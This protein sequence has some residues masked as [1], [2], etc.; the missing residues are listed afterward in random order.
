MTAHDRHTS[1]VVVTIEDTLDLGKAYRI[2]RGDAAVRLSDATRAQCAA[3]HKTLARAVKENRQIYG[4]TT[5]FG[6]LADRSVS[7]N[8]GVSLQ[9]NLVHHLATGVGSALPWTTARAVMLARLSSIAHGRS[10]ASDTA[11]DAL[12]AVLNS[13][14]APV[15]PERGTVG[16]SGDLTPLAHMVLALQGKGDFVSSDGATVPAATALA[17]IGHAPLTLGNRDALALVNGTSAMTGIAVISAVQAQRLVGW[18]LRLT[19]ALGE[20]M[21][22]RAEAWSQIFSRVRPHP[23][24]VEATQRLGKYTKGSARLVDTPMA[25]TA[26]G[27]SSRQDAYSL[28]CAPQVIGGCLD[29]LHWHNDIVTK[30]LNAVTDN[31]VFDDGDVP[32]WH[33]GNFMGQHVALASDTLSNALTVLA[34]FAERQIA[35]V[36]DEKLNGDLPAF[37][38]GGT[39][40]LN[41]GFMGA[42]VTATAIVAEMRTRGPAS[43]TSISTN[44][45]NQDVVSMGTIAA[46]NTAKAVEELSE[47]LAILA[48]VVAR[49]IDLTRT[50]AAYGTQAQLLHS[51]VRKHSEPLDGDRPLSTDITAV[52]TALR[53]TDSPI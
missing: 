20:V 31:P 4:V 32:A 13:T 21:G 30:E 23:G 19:A 1:S 14:Y 5:G 48:L 12:L 17:T 44:A 27:Q 35:R 52:A 29:A 16:A 26:A 36:T 33:G 9:Q 8:D 53:H 49:G 39:A 15:I 2:S 42:Q 28:R 34:G 11:I 50:G 3:S 46:R 51:F 38:H 45:A 37:L 24:Q 43:V 40:G 41:S 10:G 7:P 25:Q 22:A 47:V 18:S 6:P